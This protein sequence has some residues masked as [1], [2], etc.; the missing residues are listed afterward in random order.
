MLGR[1]PSSM[2]RLVVV[3]KSHP[4]VARAAIDAGAKILGENYADEGSGKIQGDW[5]NPGIEWHM[6][7]HVQSRKVT[8]VVGKF[9]LIHSLDSIKL[10]E[11][12]NRVAEELSWISR[13]S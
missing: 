7:G 3:T 2:I 11:R 12:I 1:A 10:A 6:I 9:S 4:S 5:D 8:D 13:C